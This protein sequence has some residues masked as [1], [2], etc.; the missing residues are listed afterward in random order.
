ML[1][2]MLTAT[3]IS[4]YLF[5]TLQKSEENR[6]ANTIGIILDESINRIS[7]SGKYHS[8][9]LLE[10]LQKK[11][12]ELAYIS[13]ETFDG[14]VVAHTDS[15]RN[16]K[17]VNEEE[18]D[19]SRKTQ[20]NN[21]PILT[22]RIMEGMPV[23]E[24]LSPYHTEL[25]DTPSGVV[26]IGIKVGETRSKQRII[27]FI[28]I[29]MIFVL[30][31][32]AV[33]IMKIL[34]RHFSKRLT[35]SEQ[36]L[37]DSNELFTLF[38]RHSPFYAFIKD[39]TSTES[40]VLLASDNYQQMIGIP[41]RDMVGKTMK[42]LFPADLA[43]K[44]S[45]DDWAVVIR[46]EV[47]NVDE[48]LNG[49][50]YSSIKFPIVQGGK[51]L[52]AGYT[53]DITERKLAE[54]AI[55]R[56]RALS[57]DIIN[58]LPGIFYMFD[59][60][61]KLVRWNKK[62]E[63]VTQYTPEELQK[64]SF[65]DFFSDEYKSYIA[66][67]IHHVFMEGETSA[68]ASFR[69]KNGRQIPYF[70]T[71]RLAT[72]DGKRYPL[73]V[74]IDITGRKEHEREI[75][76]IEKLE[77]VGILAG[78]I[79]HDFNNILT[80]IMGNLSLAQVFLD[81]SHKSYK[82]LAQA[83]KAAVRAEEL[84]H[85]LLTFARGGQ[86]I[87]KSIFL[88]QLVQETVS[89]VLHGSS[90]IGIIDIPDSIHA[91]EADEGQLSQVFHNL[92]INAM[93][94]MPG[95]GSLTV[96]AQDVVLDTNNVFSLS[97]GAYVRL[98]FTD[99]GCGMSED[100]LKRIFDPYYTTKVGGTG[101]GLASAHSII[102][103]HGGHIGVRSVVGVGTTFTIHLPSVGKSYTNRNDIAKPVESLQPGGS[104]LVM[105]DEKMIQET[106]IVMLEHLGYQVTACADGIDAVMLYSKAKEL[107][108]TF[109]AVIM[110]LTIPGGMGGKETAKRILALDPQACLIVS[111]GYS[112]DPIMSNY[113]AYGFTGAVAK[114]YVVDELGQ[115]LGSLL[116]HASMS[117]P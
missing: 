110:D 26:R 107:G 21:I 89:L 5:L 67:R 17:P 7:F 51:T 30:T 35:E 104:I 6:L 116:T 79:A 40:R 77:S 76:K 69:D 52:L 73:G 24:V 1:L 57:D 114:P 47:F 64:K 49:R 99:Q 82:P 31:V 65:S 8:R 113:S 117:A 87:K 58:S 63:E 3:S 45:A 84:A 2:I 20:T 9:L 55:I 111:S 19:L 80:G 41:G 36:A 90:M 74:G 115:L 92:I 11:L 39:V 98:T 28:H 56:E 112:N 68:E 50:N 18:S 105:D 44:M 109:S 48:N 103:K 60:K 32:S 66:S 93:Q 59:D 46:G 37:R 34:S 23:K 70:F 33:W 25:N 88:K 13:V 12:P 62:F 61:G 14:V 43:A 85:Q 10:E 86:P 54:E 78:G 15:T 83:A 38:M 27:L 96:T 100:V 81:T 108:R 4:G 72:L 95:G 102:S 75:L 53:I 91:I 29:L 101:L 97:S 71:G 106:A 16:D 22:E 42:E 94:A